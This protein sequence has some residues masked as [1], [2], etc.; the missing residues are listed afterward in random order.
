MYVTVAQVD[1][2]VADF[3]VCISDAENLIVKMY[4]ECS[5]Q[6]QRYI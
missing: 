6:T 1:K 2:D 4:T 5:T 3:W